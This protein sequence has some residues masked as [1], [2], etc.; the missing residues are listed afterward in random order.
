MVVG[1]EAPR[2]VHALRAG[3][4]VAAAGAAHADLFVQ[5]LQHAAVDGKL[6]LGERSGQS[7]FGD[8]RVLLHLRRIVHAREDDRG[9]LVIPDPPQPPLRRA[10][11]R[12][13]LFK[14]RLRL[15][16]QSAR[17]AAAPQRLHDDHGQALRVRVAQS[18]NAGLGMLV[19]VVELDL[20]EIPV[21]GVHQRLELFRAAVEGE[22]DV[23]NLPGRLLA[24]DPLPDAQ[25]AQARPGRGV[26][27]HMHEVIIDMVGLQ[28]LQLLPEIP[29]RVPCLADI[30]LGKLRRDIDPVPEAV[31]L[32]ERA[33][34][35]LAAGIDVGR[36]E[37]VD[38]APDGKRHLL[39]RLLLVNAAAPARKAHASEAEGGKLLAALRADSV[40]HRSS[41]LCCC[42][43]LF[44]AP[45]P[46]AADQP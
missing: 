40:L 2:N 12:R 4:A 45:P 41:L 7:V 26:I 19:Q 46:H 36:V 32:Q 39:L 31:L 9:L 11:S 14:L 37:I 13:V 28:A 24:F 35:H 43:L 44:P 27:E 21:I 23:P 22:S 18:G 5:D 29:L 30:V 10:F 8:P 15:C 38:A 42:S 20:A 34:A 33:E 16:R 1:G 17:Q 6:I 25:P 3:L